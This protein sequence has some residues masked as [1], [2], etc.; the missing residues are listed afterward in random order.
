MA[1]RSRLDRDQ[2][3]GLQLRRPK[4]G[5]PKA[6]GHK[7]LRATPAARGA[8]PD[9][10]LLMWHPDTGPSFRRWLRGRLG[11]LWAVSEPSG[12]KGGVNAGVREHSSPASAP[13]GVR[14]IVPV[15]VYAARVSAARRARMPDGRAPAQMKATA[16]IRDAGGGLRPVCHGPSDPNC[17]RHSAGR[18]G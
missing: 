10:V 12:C 14:V 9:A 1:S 18:E 7:A 11:S 6:N 5:L 15:V 16:A 2:D 13:T 3:C 8:S 4:R 17:R